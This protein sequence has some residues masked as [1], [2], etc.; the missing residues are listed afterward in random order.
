[1]SIRRREET[2][3]VAIIQ[4]RMGSTRLPGKVLMDIAGRP[5]LAQQIRRLRQCKSVDEIVIATTT[6]RTDDSVVELAQWEGVSWFRGAEQDVLSRFVGAAGQAQADVIV[7]VTADCPLI[8][9]QVTDRVISELVEHASGCDYAS[10]VLQRTYP[11]G[12]DVEAFFWD[13]LLRMDRLGRSQAARE[14]VTL[15]LRVEQPRLFLCRSVADSHNNADL[16]WTVDTADDLQM[17]RALY[18]ALSLD[19]RAVPYSEILA[20]VRAHPEMARLN[21]NVETWDPSSSPT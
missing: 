3:V 9:P 17:V 19:V 6:N 21:A 14:H 16:R 5:M 7:R 8:D 1:M 20:Y 2:K 11:R 15:V 4:A 13:T 10:N 18:V 12:L